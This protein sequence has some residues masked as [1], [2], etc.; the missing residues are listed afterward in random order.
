MG[1]GKIG[2]ELAK[3]LVKSS[4]NYQSVRD[5]REISMRQNLVTGLITTLLLSLNILFFGFSPAMADQKTISLI[6]K[7]GNRIKIGTVDITPS[8][9]GDKIKVKMDYTSFDD[10]FLNMAPFKCLPGAQIVCYIVY[11]YKTHNLLK[12]EDL[13]DLEYQLMFL[14]K[15]KGEYGIKYF[16][17][18]YYRLKRQ[19]DGSFKGLVHETDMNELAI[20]PDDKYAR[21]VGGDDLV[22]GQPEDHRFPTMEIK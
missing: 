6:D 1:T 22:K 20:P 14:R 9:K 17:G 5:Q 12:G 18:V 2:V 8:D 15:Q 21:I 4:T 3:I 11:P 7:K 16:D 19:A 10:Y 13:R